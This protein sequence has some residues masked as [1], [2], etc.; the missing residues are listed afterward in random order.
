MQ[1]DGTGNTFPS[2]ASTPH[3][4]L[5]LESTYANDV[6]EMIRRCQSENF[7]AIVANEAIDMISGMMHHPAHAL[8]HYRNESSLLSAISSVC[9][10]VSTI[11]Q[12]EQIHIETFDGKD[13][14][15]I[16]LLLMEKLWNK[17]L[18]LTQSCQ[19][20]K[21]VVVSNSSLFNI[22]AHQSLCL[23]IIMTKKTNF[24]AFALLKNQISWSSK[25]F[26]PWNVLC[27]STNRPR[28][29]FPC[30]HANISWKT[31][32]RKYLASWFNLRPINWSFF[33]SVNV[34]IAIMWLLIY[35]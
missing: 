24:I 10:H 29:L 27:K 12:L 33:Y 28:V 15:L 2:V 22:V 4:I 11:R 21:E 30:Q 5:L 3:T 6:I 7:D 26:K 17:S 8:L 25:V 9:E 19:H 31:M 16:I 18:L 13:S 20:C 32:I 23:V 35:F 34:I 14:F 1:N